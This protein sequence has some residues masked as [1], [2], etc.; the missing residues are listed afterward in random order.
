MVGRLLVAEHLRFARKV[1]VTSGCAYWL[2]A[3]ADDGYGRFTAWRG[4]EWVT[5]RAH[6]W[7]FEWT[8]GRPI[9]AGR[10]VE[11][12]CDEPLCVRR[13]HL[14]ESTQADNVAVTVA[15]DRARNA[16]RLGRADI[17]GAAARSR[18]L[19]GALLEL[20]SRTP[21]ID[22][23]VWEATLAATLE[24]VNADGNPRPGQYLL[25]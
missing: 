22:L 1:L 23:D 5:L 6:R 8:T 17:R 18:A 21:E 3:L 15:R 7:A 2:G 4:Q 12:E 24:R 16:H 11:H 10:V 14:R 20:L 19:R 25:W 13:E 9:G